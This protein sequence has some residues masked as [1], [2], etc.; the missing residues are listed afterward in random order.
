[1]FFLFVVYFYSEITRASERA[2]TFIRKTASVMT[3]GTV[4]TAE[5]VGEHFELAQKKKSQH[6]CSLL[7]F[8]VQKANQ[9]FSK[10]ALVQCRLRKNT[11]IPTHLGIHTTCGS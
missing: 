10:E 1:L 4:N 8:T 5:Y 7:L 11:T 9:L 3:A 6:S 2:N